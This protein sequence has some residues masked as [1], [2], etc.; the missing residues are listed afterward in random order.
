[1]TRG[2]EGQIV[3]LEKV[4]TI[5]LNHTPLFDTRYYPLVHL[6]HNPPVGCTCYPLVDIQG[7]PRV[8]SFWGG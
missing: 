4:Y 5:P 1:M 3:N 6:L 2:K 7:D 8:G